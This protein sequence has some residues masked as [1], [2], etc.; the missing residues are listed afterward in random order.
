MSLQAYRRPSRYRYSLVAYC[1]RGER[2]LEAGL[3]RNSTMAITAWLGHV[4]IPAGNRAPITGMD[5]FFHIG[6]CIFKE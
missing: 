2:H 1:F 6:I 3:E 5:F 4:P